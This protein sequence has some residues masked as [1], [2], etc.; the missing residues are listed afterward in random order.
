MG[1]VQ[2]RNWN[3]E[4]YKNIISA[5]EREQ[6]Q[7]KYLLTTSRLYERLD[8][9]L[10]IGASSLKKVTSKIFRSTKHLYVHQND[11]FSEAILID[12]L[13]KEAQGP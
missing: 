10:L 9:V 1:V 8:S 7:H 11:I 6:I 2:E 5:S 13:G 12:D 3:I 4:I